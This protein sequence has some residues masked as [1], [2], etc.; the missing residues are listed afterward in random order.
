[1][2]IRVTE[3]QTLE[4]SNCPVCGVMYAVDGR[5]KKNI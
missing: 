4:A 1:M 3:T 2:P 5:R